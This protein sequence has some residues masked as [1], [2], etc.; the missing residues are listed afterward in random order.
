MAQRGIK[1]STRGNLNKD[2]DPKAMRNGDYEDA[3]DVLHINKGSNKSLNAEPT[4][5]NDFAFTI[6]PRVAHNKQ[7]RFNMPTQQSYEA[8]IY[9]TDGVS[10]LFTVNFSNPTDFVV[11]FAVGAGSAGI[12]INFVETTSTYVTVEFVQPQYYD[13]FV[14]STGV[15]EFTYDVLEES[16][17]PNYIGVPKIIGSV[18]LLGD[19]FIFSTTKT[20]E[21]KSF[22]IIDI[23]NSSGRVAVST[24]QPHGL[25]TGDEINIV[26]TTLGRSADGIWIVT[27]LSVTTVSLELS[28]GTSLNLTIPV[29]GSLT[30][31]TRGYGEI[32]V[33]VKDENTGTWNYTR[34][35][36]SKEFDFDTFYLI[37][38]D[39]EVNFLGKSIY[40]NQVKK[41][42]PK[43]FYYNQ[44]TY[45]QD[46]ALSIYGGQYEYGLIETEL[47]SQNQADKLNVR[48]IQQTNVG[49]LRS[50]A[51]RYI[52]RGINETGQVFTD[53]KW[54][55][56]QVNVF[57][58]INYPI[59]GIED[60]LPTSKSNIIE[61]YNINAQLW[62]FV[63]F[64]YIYYSGGAISGNTFGR[65]EVINDADTFIY[66]H[67]GFEREEQ[68]DVTSLQNL[69]LRF[70]NIGSQRILDNRLVYANID[71][72]SS[73]F[74]LSEYFKT[75]TH[76]LEYKEIT[77]AKNNVIGDYMSVDACAKSTGYMLYE[78]YRFGA[79][80]QFKNGQVQTYWIDD[81]RID[82][83]PI[84]VTTPNRR[85]NGLSD[86]RL[87]N[88][89]NF[90]RVFFP[91][92]YFNLNYQLNGIVLR[93]FIDSISIVRVDMQEQFREVI[94]TGFVT[95]TYSGNPKFTFTGGGSSSADFFTAWRSLESAQAGGYNS[96][97]G[98]WEK[99]FCTEDLFAVPYSNSIVTGVGGGHSY[100]RNKTVLNGYFPDVLYGYTTIQKQANDQL[101]L[102]DIN[103]PANN[104]SVNPINQSLG[105]YSYYN[106]FFQSAPTYQKITSDIEECIF[107]EGGQPVVLNTNVYFEKNLSIYTTQSGTSQE[108]TELSTHILSRS[109]VIRVK[110]DLPTTSVFLFGVYFRNKTAVVYNPDT[111]KFGTR[112]QSKYTPTGD[113]FY[114]STQLSQTIDIFGGDSF[115]QRTYIKNR[116]RTENY[117]NNTAPFSFVINVFDRYN[118]GFSFYSQNR[119]NIDLRLTKDGEITYP[120]KSTNVGETQIYNW[121]NPKTDALIY[122]AVNITY[123]FQPAKVF[124][125]YEKDKNLPNISNLM[126]RI[127]Y[128]ILKP[129]GS[130]IDNYRQFPRFQYYDLDPKY[131]EITHIEVL[132]NELFVWQERKFNRMFFNTTGVLTTI[133]G[134][135]SVLGNQG[136]L[137][138]KPMSLSA[139]GSRHKFSV[140][141]GTSQGGQDVAYWI[142]TENGMLMRFGADGSVAIS[143]IWGLMGFLND[144]LKWADANLKYTGN[145]YGYGIYGVWDERFKE[146]IWTIRAAKEVDDWAIRQRYTANRSDF[147]VVR[148][149]NQTE[150][151]TF[152]D[153]FDIFICTQA[154]T[155]ASDN[156]PGVGVNWQSYWTVVPHTDKDYYNEYTLALN[157]IKNGFSTF[158]TH[159]PAIYLK[160]RNKF[161]SPHPKMK[162]SNA[163]FEHREGDYLT[164]YNYEGEEQTSVG[165]IMPIINID[166]EA[167]KWYMA[168]WMVTKEPP[169]RVDMFT[170]KHKTHV[171]AIDFEEREGVYV[172]SIPNTEDINGNTDQDTSQL[173][174][175]YLK[176]KVLFEPKKFQQ[177]FDFVTLLRA[178][179]RSYN[180]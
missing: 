161:L 65:F 27:V 90:T 41:N 122:E 78:T 130:I 22:T 150:F 5:G 177:F 147:S 143:I 96:E 100:K 107:S 10:I 60:G 83:S 50:G 93:D 15:N 59:S 103:Q 151:S 19:L 21:T 13:W 81:I 144:N 45:I 34:L 120:I 128:S 40:F 85:L 116:T 139:F 77:S 25:Q 106:D 134:D 38:A 16:L 87:N 56:Y 1:Q 9:K 75:V 168:L 29:T 89:Q 149:Y 111:S 79:T 66:N 163:A 52:V 99:G 117:P 108:S 11:N 171:E 72:I 42:L 64:G 47:P 124:S 74:D 145:R 138:R 2:V 39:K 173:Y 55:S 36:G 80:V 164:W 18:D 57:E 152:E 14:S 3:L 94:C 159:K 113:I 88:G 172:A 126:T 68:L 69:S 70:A 12:Q 141:K 179:Q 155:S 176:V 102:I 84:N 137:S 135:I 142:N 28:D 158:Y 71:T 131:G 112:S 8:T 156:E 160:Y 44:D 37:E 109:N 54:I 157:E 166:P 133:E 46:G 62:K 23:Y 48:F 167:I 154:H 119:A 73:D 58:A 20:Q 51:Y 86:I 97:T 53:W 30:T 121:L 114:L 26:G 174:G 35:L 63:E 61:A 67:T 132:N 146:A 33:A 180:K 4:L 32:G 6:P 118:T 104:T 165:Y 115:N 129:Q 49:S 95:R 7:I 162:Y 127:W 76:S 43:V 31:Y 110:N 24:S 153:T 101:I 178:S 125:F 136:V 123:S 105:Q 91:R 82:D 140:I 92:F 98:G 169:F 170:D 148:N 175:A 17:A